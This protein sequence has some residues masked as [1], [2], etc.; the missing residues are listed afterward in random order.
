VH[1]GDAE[2][3]LASGSGL[4]PK[5]RGEASE[6]ALK[7]LVTQSKSEPTEMPVRDAAWAR[8]QGIALSIVVHGRAFTSATFGSDQL[9]A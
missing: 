8:E 1:A 7:S 4:S 6:A 3:P 5:R 2:R 9:N